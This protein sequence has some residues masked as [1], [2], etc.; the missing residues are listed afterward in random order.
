MSDDWKFKL[1]EERIHI[2]IYTFVYP[3]L[4]LA[5]MFHKL[6]NG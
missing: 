3:S 4:E 5:T 1:D 6:C 2:L